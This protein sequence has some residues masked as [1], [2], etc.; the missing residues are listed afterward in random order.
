MKKTGANQKSVQL[1]WTRVSHF[2]IG[3]FFALITSDQMFCKF[4][5]CWTRTL[6]STELHKHSAMTPPHLCRGPTGPPAG[7]H[8]CLRRWLTCWPRGL[9]S[10]P[11]CDSLWVVVVGRTLLESPSRPRWSPAAAPDSTG[12][13]GIWGQ[14]SKNRLEVCIWT[15]SFFCSG[16]RRFLPGDVVFGIFAI[17]GKSTKKVAPASN[18]REA[19]SKAGAGGWA[20]LWRFGLQTFPLPATRLKV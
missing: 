3:F 11:P 14:R 4:N 16:S 13:S 18:Q 5:S 1:F 10:P 9:S 6:V 12:H 2:L 19:V 8:S 15:N 17:V 7:S 20:I